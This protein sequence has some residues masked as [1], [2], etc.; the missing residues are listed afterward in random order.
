MPTDPSRVMGLD[1]P[2]IVRLAERKATVEEL[3]GIVPGAILD[4]ERDAEDELDLLVNNKH[5]GSGIAVKIGENFGIQVTWIGDEE[6]RLDA[7]EEDA[8]DDTVSND[9]IA[10]LLMDGMI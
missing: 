8:G 3:L 7:M 1:V 9:D 10:S 5:L 2:I 6:E 4:L